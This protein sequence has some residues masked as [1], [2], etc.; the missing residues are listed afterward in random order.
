[1]YAGFWLNAISGLLLLA[2]NASSMLEN[3]MFYIKLGCIALAV[4]C[5]RLLRNGVF[6]DIA[7]LEA[8]ADSTQ[9][10]VLAGAL[11][12]FWGG[13]IV[14]GRLTAYPYF[15]ALWLGI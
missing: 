9:A 5:L 12:F 4:L 11:I 3:T 13:A 14:A 7:E 2:A 6:G 1:M 15:V 8:R 10:R